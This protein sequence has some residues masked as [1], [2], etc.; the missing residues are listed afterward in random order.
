VSRFIRLRTTWVLAAAA[1][2]LVLPQESALAGPAGTPH[3][4][5]LRT[6]PPTDLAFRILS[7]KT[8]S[9]GDEIRFS[10]TI[11]N[12]GEGPFELRAVNAGG[13]TTAYQRVYTHDASGNPSLASET[14]AGTFTFHS[15]HNHWHFEGFARYEL[16]AVNPDGGM[17]AVLR[18]SAKVSFCMIDSTFVNS[19]LPHSGWSGSGSR[20]SRCQANDTQGISVGYGD[21]YHSGLAGQSITTTGL[22]HSAGT[23]Y[24]LASEAD[25]QNHISETNETNN[26]AAVKI[27]F[28]SKGLRVIG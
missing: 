28:W 17:G 9:S 3:L 10:N 26:I 27:Q 23:T 8:G 1:A 19:S 2:I 16:R 18:T 20:Y 6:L 24:W 22:P 12:G 7:S 5:D 4:P 13:T 25:P 15:A 21:R 14:P 11:W